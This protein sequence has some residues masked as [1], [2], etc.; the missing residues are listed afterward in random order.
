MTDTGASG[1]PPDE[2][3]AGE[4][5]VQ[6]DAGGSARAEF[7]RRRSKR[8]DRVRQAHPKIGGLLLAVTEDPQS[9]AAWDKG[10][11]GEETLGG[12]LNQAAGP[13]L[14]VLHDRRA[15]GSSGLSHLKVG[16]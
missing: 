15:P 14:R 3:A 4:T 12:R 8:A 6:G 2:L 1:T 11:S 13:L 9:T 16:L 10:A 5:Y 7:E